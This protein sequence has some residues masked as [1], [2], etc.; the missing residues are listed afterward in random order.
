MHLS[1]TMLITTLA[2][3]SKTL[4]HLALKSPPQFMVSWNPTATQIDDNNLDPL[5]P[6]GRNY[7]C[8]NGHLGMTEASSVATWPAGS[9]QSMSIEGAAVRKLSSSF[10]S[11]PLQIPIRQH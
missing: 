8:M 6:D 2:L 3:S 11:Q 10:Y 5:F 4:A 1:T 7:P 9:T